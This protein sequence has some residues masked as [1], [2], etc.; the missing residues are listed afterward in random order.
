[1]VRRRQAPRPFDPQGGPEA[2]NHPMLLSRANLRTKVTLLLLALSLGPLLISGIVNENRAVHSGKA[3]VRARHAQAARFAAY[4][5][6]TLFTD[7]QRDLRLLATRFPVEG[8]DLEGIAARLDAANG[9]LPEVSGGDDI[10]VFTALHGAQTRTFLALQDGRI[11]FAEPY[12]NVPQV[13]NLKNLQWFQ[14]IPPEGGITSGDLS[15]FTPQGRP[16]LIALVPLKRAG[17]HPIGWVGHILDSGTIDEI[18]EQSVWINRPTGEPRRE[19]RASRETM[20]LMTPQG[21]FAGHTDPALVGRYAPS[22]LLEHRFPGTSEIDNGPEGMVLARAEVGRT[23][24]YVMLMTSKH[25]AYRDVYAVIWLLT[26]VIVLTFIFVLLFADY[27]ASILLRPILELERGAHMIGAGALDYRIELNRHGNDE[28]G[29][30]AETFNQMGESLLRTRR[31]V[32]AYGRHLKVANQELDAMVYAITHDLKKSL[33]GIEA[34]ATFVEEDYR[35]NLEQE[36]VDMLR[37]IVQNVHRIEKLANDLIGLVEH[38]RERGENTR[39]S[40]M[41]MLRD[42]REHC[43]EA[44]LGEVVIQP[45]MPEVVGDRVRINLLFTNLISNGLKF[46]RSP[47]PRVEIEWADLGNYW[48]VTVSDNGIG[49]DERYHDHIF[50]LFFRLNSKDEFDGTG[51][52]LNLCRR[53]VEEHRGTIHVESQPGKGSRFIVRLPKD[54]ALLT[55]PGLER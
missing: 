14:R 29:R 8:L 18:V 9:L 42:A 17:G 15:P 31:E 13:P 10:Q 11:F 44:Q 48:E 28:L 43:M 4:A 6:S 46:N 32:D 3:A 27:L 55:S 24:W 7:V 5:V 33:R 35:D 49:I 19:G 21:L 36:G 26:A 23:G 41:D 30:L 2:F 51:T 34:F 40:L 22:Y 16:S 1:M 38:E 20:L 52:G 45:G 37:S 12:H 39:F 54:P 47:R 50:E 53:I 25:A